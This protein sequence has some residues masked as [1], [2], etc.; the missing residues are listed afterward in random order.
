MST[1]ATIHEDLITYSFR[2][3][4][5]HRRGTLNSA[6]NK[7]GTLLFLMDGSFSPVY[8][9]ELQYVEAE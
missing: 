2:D 5:L 8:Y 1:E 4:H 7:G 6:V 3:N 9:G